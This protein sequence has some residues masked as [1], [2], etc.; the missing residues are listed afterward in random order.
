M[1]ETGKQG[2]VVRGVYI[3]KRGGEER[4]GKKPFLFYRQFIEK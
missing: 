2:K 3:K 1:G 4:G